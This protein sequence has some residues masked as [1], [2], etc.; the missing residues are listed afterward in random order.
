MIEKVMFVAGTHGNE[1]S[2]IQLIKNWQHNGCPYKYSSF[3]LTSML[4]NEEAISR[5]VRFVDEDL[6]RQFSP[7]K[8][9][10][11][12]IS[13]ESQLAID[14]NAKLGPKGESQYDLVVD[15]HNT[16]SN[17]GAT[18][19]LPSSEPFYVTM[20]RYIKQVLPEANILV[21]DEKPYEQ[22]PYLCTLGKHGVMIEVGAQPQG[23]LRED[24]YQLTTLLAGSV[25]AFCEAFNTNK[26]THLEPCLA[27]R[28]V[29]NILFPLNEKGERT[30][31]IHHQLQDADFVPLLSGQPIFKSFDGTEIVWEGEKETFPH[32]INEAAYSKQHI[33]FATAESFVL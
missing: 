27:F 13:L 17:M 31:M 11:P 12:D 1:M 14:I 25:V 16:T 9:T 4:A 19:I 28:F 7:A 33:A 3:E 6:N 10:N 26:L 18:L 29:E 32:F 21:E 5:H 30:A 8:L 23:V 15:I 20:A 2:G 24:V 22:H